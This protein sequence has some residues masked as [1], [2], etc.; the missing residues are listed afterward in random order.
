DII[1]NPP[2]TRLLKKAIEWSISHMNGIDMLLYQG[3]EA[4]ELWTGQKAPVDTMR[5]SLIDSVY[6]GSATNHSPKK[7]S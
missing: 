2:E 4:F 7:S 1:Y 3:V 5:Q 6:S